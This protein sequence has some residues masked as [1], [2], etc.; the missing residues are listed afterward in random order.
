MKYEFKFGDHDSIARQSTTK[1]ADLLR[2]A[3]ELNSPEYHVFIEFNGHVESLCIGVY[4]GGWVRDKRRKE[5]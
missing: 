2:L 3:I 4:P 1:L 5:L